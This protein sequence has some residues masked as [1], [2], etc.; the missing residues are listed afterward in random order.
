MTQYHLD[1]RKTVVEVDD[2][3]EHRILLGCRSGVGYAAIGIQSALITDADGVGVGST[4][5]RT[6]PLY[7]TA[8]MYLALARNI[9]MIADVKP[10]VHL[11]MVVAQLLRSAG[12]AFPPLG[13]PADLQSA[14]K[15][16]PN[17]FML[18]GYVI[19]SPQAVASISIG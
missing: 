10:A 4:G 13:V 16:C 7:R 19:P 5:M 11:H 9:I 18:W 15:K 2:Q 14:V 1:V 17:L 8:L 6:H 12:Y 3:P